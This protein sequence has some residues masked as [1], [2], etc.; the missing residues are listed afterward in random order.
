MVTDPLDPTLVILRF[1]K[2][3]K[4]GTELMD[5]VE[6]IEISKAGGG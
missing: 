5:L 3:V 2:E 6:S 4:K 1:S